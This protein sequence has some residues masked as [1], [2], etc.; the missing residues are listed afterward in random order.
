[1]NQTEIVKLLEE[2]KRIKGEKRNIAICTPRSLERDLIRLASLLEKSY[3]KK[4]AVSHLMRAIV[5]LYVQNLFEG[6]GV[7]P[8]GEKQEDGVLNSAVAPNV[9]VLEDEV[10]TGEE[11]ESSDDFIAQLLGD[12]KKKSGPSWGR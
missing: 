2:T 12:T 6:S 1:M 5:A 7:L 10:L 11:P 3:G 8:I 4:I 9:G